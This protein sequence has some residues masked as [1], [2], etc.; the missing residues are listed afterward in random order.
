VR[1]AAK[2]FL[3]SALVI[4]VLVGV[5][6]LSLRGIGRLVSVNQQITVRS[7][8]ALR[9]A[10]S[11]RDAL[12]SMGR[13][14]TRFLVIRDF[15][16]LALWDERATRFR[17]DV[18][19]LAD[20][21]TTSRQRRLLADVRASFEDYAVMVGEERR[22]FGAGQRELALHLAE[23][24]ARRRFERVEA[25]LE[26]LVEATHAAVID[27]QADASRLE[28]RTWN[29]VLLALG[30]ALVLAL[31]G[32]ALIAVR[33]A[34]SLRTLSDAMAAVAAGSFR[35]PVHL[36]SRDELDDLARSFNVMAARLRQM[37][38]VKAEFFT[39]LSH[40]LRSPLTSVREA[41]HLLRDGVAGALG[42][43]Q[44]RLVAIIGASSD[45]LLKLV[46]QMLE[47][48]RLRAGMIPLE[49]QKVDLER[50]VERALDE[51]R[52]QA[53]EAGVRL[54]REQRGEGFVFLGDEDRLVQVL[55]NLLANAIR[56]TG[57]EG[58]VTVRM[59]ATASGLELQVED[60]GRGIP[61]QALPKI[62][63]W[64]QQAHPGQGGTG[65]GL[66]I[67]RG[68]VQAHGGEV[69][70]ESQEGRGS[71]FRV[72]LPRDRAAA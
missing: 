27:D 66:A 21:A 19:A 17:D 67:V 37:D 45:R 61:P 40:E 30:A 32:S 47:I 25:S 5:A 71:L 46:N 69:Q 18:Q 60:T 8:P 48:S 33:T 26:G 52:P 29:A 64:Y 70:V 72:M 14:E 15:Q 54:E 44:A 43:K 23:T 13:L 51:L 34:R 2:I 55:V 49:Q 57:P 42:P 12:L 65:L 7:V 41:A 59:V 35:E 28:A 9:L 6:A 24:E 22:L 56:F 63:D 4:A 10:A 36:R 1:F 38:E 53:H 58:R 16:Y 31:A 68:I 3:T 11:A 20:L 50:V 62:F 39:T